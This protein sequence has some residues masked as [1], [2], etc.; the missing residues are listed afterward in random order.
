MGLR[1]VP[2][3]GHGA[4]AVPDLE[5]RAVGR[6]RARVVEAAFRVRVEERPVG[7]GLPDLSPGA[8]AGPELDLGSV[9]GAGA[10]DV[11]ALPERPDGAV[12]GV[13]R[14]LLRVGAAAGP[15]LDVGAVRGVRAGD[16]DTLAA[17]AGDLAGAACAA[18]AT[19]R[20]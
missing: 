11:H 18:A 13:P 12:A 2:D 7:A 5:L 4:V 10:R 9:G 3:L 6:V 14:P 8:V 16:V 1:H 19:A 15:E 20:S 17:A